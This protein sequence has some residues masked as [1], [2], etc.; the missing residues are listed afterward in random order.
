MGR[1]V[2]VVVLHQGVGGGQWVGIILQLFFLPALL[3]FFSLMCVF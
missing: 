1:Y 2:G 3:G